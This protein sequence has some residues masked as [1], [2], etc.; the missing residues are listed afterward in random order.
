[1]RIRI[2][3]ETA[4]EAVV[5]LMNGETDC[6]IIT[7]PA[8]IGKSLRV[9]QLLTFQSTIICGKQYEELASEPRSLRELSSYPFICPARQSG[10]YRFYQQL[11]AMYNVPFRVDIET[12][13]MDQVLPMIRRNLGIGFFPQAL[14]PS[15]LDKDQ[16]REIHLREPIPPRTIYLVEDP[17]HPQ[18]I[19][20]KSFLHLLFPKSSRKHG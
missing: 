4:Q 3:N 6:A 15:A 17:S 10:S 8:E 7:T 13:T 5:S 9:T 12:S 20:M 19:A 18:S 11:F 14:L 1:M 2:T 16:L